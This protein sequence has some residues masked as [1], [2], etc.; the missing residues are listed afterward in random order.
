LRNTSLIGR[1][2]AI[3][4]LLVAVVAV[5]VIIL[6]GGSTYTVNAIFVN[7]SQ[8]VTGDQVEVAG[9]P[10]GSVSDISLTQNGQARL[11]LE[12]DNK[13][14]RPLREG[15]EATI[16]QTSLSGIANRYVDLRLGPGSA[17]EIANGG[18]L[19][20]THTT[21]AV[22]FDQLFNT[23][24]APTRKGLQNVIQGSAS[25]YAGE[26]QA[27]QAAWRYL[28]PAVAS[29]SMLFREINRDTAH[30]T[31]FIVESSRLVTD[32]SQRSTDLSALVQN[33]ATTTEALSSQRTALGQSIQQLPGFMRLADT[34]FTNLRGTLDAV[35]PLVDASKPVAP[36]L[37]KLLVQLKP[38][39]EDSVPTVR[40]LANIVSRPGADNDLTDL[41]ELGVPLAGATVRDVNA[42]G[43]RRLGAFPQSTIALHDS[44]PELA[45]ARPYAADLTGWF[46]GFAH[47]GFSDA[48]GNASR[49]AAQLTLTALPLDSVNSLL[50]GINGLLPGQVTG[51]LSRAT[52]QLAAAGL[53]TQQGDRC[54][55]SME[56]GA[57]FFPESGFPCNP[58]EVP[59]GP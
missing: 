25:Q 45:V 49:V 35:T 33:L 8:I 41:T 57:V 17:P 29:S 24:D 42:N 27:A 58:R 38:L 48:N 39:A 28:N 13:T 53:V 5:A 7:A 11:K 10:I 14:Y 1:A 3:A 47:P 32:V 37:Q 22:D 26:G 6:Q 46:E 20:T 40:D 18:T 50:N 34:T 51:T 4:A 16:R 43:K 36:K 2:A 44:T 52:S 30:F 23:L 19:P 56:R 21:S 15:T 54:P 55:G 9:N 31:R 12:I 59:T